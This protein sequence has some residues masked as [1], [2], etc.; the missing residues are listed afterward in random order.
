MTDE[1]NISPPN[2]PRIRFFDRL[3]A[4]WDDSEQDPLD[5]INRI[6]GVAGLLE[7]RSGE[8]VLEVGCGTGQLTGWLVEQVAPGRVVAVDFSS[9]M[10]G[11]ARAKGID[12]NFRV[13][14]ACRD[15]LGRACFDAALCF[16]SFPH[17]RDKPAAVRNLAQALTPGGRLMVM[18][19]NS[20]SAISAFHDQVGGDVVGDH[21]PDQ[22]GWDDLLSAEGLR[23]VDWIDR[24]GL[25]FLKAVAM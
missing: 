19:F 15:E 4:D 14:D 25:F 9:G 13:A 21:L 20:I 12:A 8:A 11:K 10:L 23:R 1:T 6:R 5:T 18:H 7:L 16:H 22:Q 2:D 3:A 17:F 24:E